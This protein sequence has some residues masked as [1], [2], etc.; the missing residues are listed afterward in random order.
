VPWHV[1]ERK[2]RLIDRGKGEAE[3]NRDAAFLFLFQTIGIGTRER[4]N[5]SALAVIDV[6]G[7]ANDDVIH[8]TKII[9]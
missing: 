9:M 7:G 1:H 2:R 3:L 5:E 4:V 6:T 8:G